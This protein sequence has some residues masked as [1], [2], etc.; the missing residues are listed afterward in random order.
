[1][2]NF[3][4][5]T[6]ALAVAGLSMAIILEFFPSMVAVSSLATIQTISILVGVFFGFASAFSYYLSD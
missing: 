5:I 4:D 1:M 6:A 3:T 2:K